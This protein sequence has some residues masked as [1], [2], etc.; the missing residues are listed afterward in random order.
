M[1]FFFFLISFF[2]SS[3]TLFSS[4]YINVFFDTSDYH[5]ADKNWG[6]SKDCIG[7]MFFANDGG[8][9]E[10]DGIEWQL[11]KLKYNSVIRSV[12]AD[13]DRIYSGSYEEF[14]FW[15]R[16]EYGH[17]QYQSLS[18]E[19]PKSTF[20]NDDIWKIIK[21]RGRIYFQSFHGVYVYDDTG[22]K[23]LNGP[24]VFSMWEVGGDLIVQE[25][26]GPLYTIV[27]DTYKKIPDSDFFS[28]YKVQAVLPKDE[29]HQIIFTSVGDIFL[30]DGE[31]FTPIEKVPELMDKE[32]NTVQIDRNGNYCIA[33][34]LD[35]IFILSQQGN[36]VS[37]INTL[38]QLSNN[39]VLST[40]ID[41]N[42]NIWGGL[43]EGIVL[44]K[45][46]DDLS[47]FLDY[48]NNVGSVYAACVF[49]DKLIIG[50][51]QGLFYTAYNDI[52]L[53]NFSLSHFQKIDNFNGQVWQLS[54]I[55]GVIY[56]A[57][58]AG[59]S[60]INDK[61]QVSSP[62]AFNT[63]VFSIFK[64]TGTD[65]I[66]LGTYTNL[67]KI[68]TKTKELTHFLAIKEPIKE[69]LIDHL[70]NV[71]LEHLNRGVFKC[72]FNK[73]MDS[74]TNFVYYNS[75]DYEE[76][77][78]KQNI[79][80]IGE[81]VAFLGDDQFFIYDDVANKTFPLEQLNELF[82][83][84]D[85]LKNVVNFGRNNFWV[86]SSNTLYELY[87]TG[88]NTRFKN[89]I[90]LEINDLSMV[91]NFETIIPL[92]DSVD[93]ICI[94][95]GFVLYNPK[96][97]FN[98][99]SNTQKPIVTLFETTSDRKNFLRKILD[100]QIVIPYDQ[101]SIKVS[102]FSPESLNRNLMIQYQLEGFD[103]WSNPSQIN[104]ISYDRLPAGKYTLALR[105]IDTLGDVSET[106]RLYFS[107]SKHWSV[108][109]WAI[110]M[111]L[112]IISLIAFIIHHYVLTRYRNI[113]LLKVRERELNRLKN[114]NSKLQLEM[115]EKEAE[116]LSQTSFIIQK[117]ELMNQVKEELNLY[118]EKYSSNN[119]KPLYNKMNQLLNSIDSEEDWTNFMFK[120]E[121]KHP[122]FFKY[123]K[124]NFPQLTANDM[125]LCACL[126]LN[127][128]SKEIASLMNLSVRSVENN[129][130]RL[131]KKL[132]LLPE[133]SLTEFVMSI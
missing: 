20:G 96:V 88:N 29:S 16:D 114:S 101:N 47:F 94:N 35:G 89:K 17:L 123:L 11:H 54:A 3:C 23:R 27:N 109:W 80:K 122:I 120:F 132:G 92:N 9:L 40:F 125:K 131:R 42:N 118:Q 38:N 13:G 91:N 85:N 36:V 52:F 78:Y 53:D 22:V 110:L 82:S 107:I 111:Y 41:D 32:I 4:S 103:D 129:R 83:G 73:T 64:I 124:V 62:F 46:S 108:T 99:T 30:Y 43:A 56:C 25:I 76:L 79:F 106:S 31:K 87:T 97:Q 2:V 112:I 133:Q 50:T 69:I 49:K 127:L 72:Q 121:E 12:L 115:R 95:K 51:N 90:D 61:M 119:F 67:S 14:G 84:V 65:E 104:E 24:N 7:R 59:L 18:A 21:S 34:L 48:K 57:H 39:S 8:L 70:G 58:N 63:G 116:M 55:D 102:F 10:F 15:Q 44:L 5:A 66:L 37:H 1:R 68:N 77:P 45:H 86:L 26:A 105:T 130:S 6:I 81:R 93:M 117:K 100:Q 126:K 128:E 60:V 75:L 74:I 98:Y 19:L 33:T 71:W 28:D 113:H